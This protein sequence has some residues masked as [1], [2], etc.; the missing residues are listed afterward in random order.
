MLVLLVVCFV[1]VVVVCCC[2]LLLLLL[3]TSWVLVD[4]A[5]LV[6]MSGWFFVA[7]TTH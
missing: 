4:V 2:L 7:F 6:A 5:L 3:V 1:G